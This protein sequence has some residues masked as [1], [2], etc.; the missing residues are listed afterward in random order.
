MY[1]TTM[2]KKVVNENKNSCAGEVKE[3]IHNER[4]IKRKEFTKNTL[5]SEILFISSSF[6]LSTYV[7]L[8]TSSRV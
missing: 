2:A 6:R 4:R 8:Q 5:S 7:C 3:N 1:P